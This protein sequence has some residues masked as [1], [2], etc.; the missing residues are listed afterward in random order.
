[1]SQEKNKDAKWGFECPSCGISFEERLTELEK[2]LE[3][4]G[5]ENSNNQRKRIKVGDCTIYPPFSLLIKCYSPFDYPREEP[6]FYAF[7]TNEARN[8]IKKLI[9]ELQEVLRALE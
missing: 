9:S 5:Y 1:M 4:A 3:D 6:I 8:K 7:S 2:R